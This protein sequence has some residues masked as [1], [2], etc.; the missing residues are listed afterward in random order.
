MYEAWG[1][2][3]QRIACSP[4]HQTVVVSTADVDDNPISIEAHSLY[5]DILAGS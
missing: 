3:G 1:G 5:A 2:Q 4:H